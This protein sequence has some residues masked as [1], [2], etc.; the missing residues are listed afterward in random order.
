MWK[1]AKRTRRAGEPGDRYAVRARVPERLELAE[2]GTSVQQQTPDILTE[3]VAHEHDVVAAARVQRPVAG[4][5]QSAL[6]DEPRRG[7]AAALRR[8]RPAIIA[9]CKRRSPSKGVLREPYDPVA[10]ARGYAGRG[11]RGDLGAHQR[12]LLRRHAR[13]SA[14]GACRGADP[15]P[16]QGLR[17][18]RV[19]ARRGARV[20]CGCGAADRGGARA[21][22]AARAARRRRGARPRRPDRGPRRTRARGRTR[23]R[24]DDHRRQQ[25]QPCAPS[26]R[27]SRPASGWRGWFPP[28]RSWSPRAA[29]A[30][31]A[32]LQRLARAGIGAFL[33]G[34]AFM[35][36]PEPG[37]ALAAM[38]AQA[39]PA[40]EA[41]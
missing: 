11:R 36:A 20:G 28:A 6:Y 4:L 12:A 22:S 23:D 16:A 21:G 38:I 24:C 3:I 10:I 34:E 41:R 29:C 9:E 8:A 39:A 40:T 19:P 25:P 30:N 14:R 18:R 31:G 37:R 32:D 7:F 1:S 35:T 33:V 15:G 17:R 27:R 13:G 2:G 26:S 5:R